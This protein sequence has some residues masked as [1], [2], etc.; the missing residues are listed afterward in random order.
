M[1]GENSKAVSVR[2]GG[3]ALFFDSGVVIMDFL[4]F[5]LSVLYHQTASVGLLL[6][7]GGPLY[8]SSL[9]LWYWPPYRVNKIIISLTS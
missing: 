1:D 6:C 5:F 8:K 2:R 4:S 9:P 3:R 7:R